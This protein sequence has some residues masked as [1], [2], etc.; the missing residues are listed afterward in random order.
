MWLNYIAFIFVGWF[1]RSSKIQDYCAILVLYLF[2]VLT[3]V[4]EYG[5][6][7]KSR[8]TKALLPALHPG[9]AT[10]FGQVI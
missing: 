7:V 6:Y 3:E 8:S 5:H 10:K 4:T 9:F 1:F 2:L